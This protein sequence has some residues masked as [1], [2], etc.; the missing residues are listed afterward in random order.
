MSTTERGGFASNIGFILAAAGSAVGLGNIW[1]FPYITG[2]YGG[3]AFVLVY[4]AC[5]L[6][7][8]APLMYAELMIGKRG[9]LSPVG[10]IRKLT[11]GQAAGPAVAWLTGGLAVATGFIILSFYSVVAGWALHF[12][13]LSAGILQGGA[14]AGESFGA[15]AGSPAWSVG[16]HTL[17]MLM[18]ISVVV[19]GVQSGIERACKVLMPALFAILLGL[20]AY[21]GITFG[22]TDA[23]T[24]LFVPDFSK[25]SAE[26]VLEALG[27]S[28]FTLSLGMGA[29]IT[30]GS[31]L[32]DE[33]SI[34]RDGVVVA[35]L[36]TTIALVAGVIIFTVVFAMDKEPQ[37]GPGLV[38]VTLPDLFATIP[39][40]TAVAIAFFFMLV[41]AAWSSAIS[42]LEVV[43]S[44]IVDEFSLPRPAVT[45]LA[46]ASIWLAGVACAVF[47]S[48]LD[49]G[50]Q[51]T[52]NYML[53]G[54]GLLVAIVAGW[55]VPEADRRAGFAP[56][57]AAGAILEPLWT[58]VTRIVTPVLVAV[59]IVW[60][61]G[62]LDT[63]LGG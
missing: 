53:P 7:V 1:K 54:G 19:G 45:A 5:I 58:W 2:H 33:R 24:F 11:K 23:L 44:F 18:T 3:G 34:I 12:L 51:I 43:V 41:F 35:I 62:L 21:V 48:V 59:V 60:K 14:T 32:P 31:Y 55:M 16:W 30:Y 56:F 13:A 27:H 42:I 38:F 22:L 46:G 9:N 10:A 49:F 4:L 36:D 61:V 47:P 52:T 26:A 40:G 15:V 6:L 63:L 50:D 57:G 20:L 29:M 25:L 17:F 39:G 28:F 8:G 37:A